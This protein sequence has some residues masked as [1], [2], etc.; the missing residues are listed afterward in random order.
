MEKEED[1][2]TNGKKQ[3]GMS[4]LFP[5]I[6]PKRQYLRNRFPFKSF[7]ALKGCSP[8]SIGFRGSPGQLGRGL[9]FN[10]KDLSCKQGSKPREIFGNKA[11]PCNDLAALENHYIESKALGLP[12]KIAKFAIALSVLN[13]LLKCIQG[14]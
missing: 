11:I 4:V 9:K 6:F 2:K 13:R 3:T 7:F 14:G 10:K 1:D 8:I 5:F 12:A